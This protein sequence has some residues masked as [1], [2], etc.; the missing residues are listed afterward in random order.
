MRQILIHV[1][2]GVLTPRRALRDIRRAGVKLDLYKEKAAAVILSTLALKEISINKAE[3]ML[4]EE[5]IEYEK[6]NLCQI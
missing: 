6:D 1:W 4:K 5:G 2:Q 3:E